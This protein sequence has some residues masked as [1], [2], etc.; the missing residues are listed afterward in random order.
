MAGTIDPNQVK[1]LVDSLNSLTK[2]LG[3]S[4]A[5]SGYSS[6]KTGYDNFK[7]GESGLNTDALRNAIKNNGDAAQQLGNMFKKISLATKGLDKVFDALEKNTRKLNDQQRQATLSIVDMMKAGDDFVKTLDDLDKRATKAAQSIEK[8]KDAVDTLKSATSKLSDLELKR[9]AIEKNLIKARNSKK[10]TS[11]LQKTLNEFDKSI[12]EQKTSIEGL[13]KEFNEIT[14]SFIELNKATGALNEAD[15]EYL[16]NINDINTSNEDYLK[17]INKITGGVEHLKQ[18]NDS[19]AEILVD[20]AKTN[21]EHLTKGVVALKNGLI[22][23]GKLLFTEAIPMAFNDYMARMKNNIPES[24]YG[25]SLLMGVSESQRSDLIGSNRQALRGLGGGNEYSG[26]D[27]QLASL[28]KTAYQFGVYGKDALETALAYQK[29]SQGVGVNAGDVQGQ[30][31]QM[32]LMHQFSEQIGVTDGAL[33]D[34]YDSLGDMGELSV[35]NQ[36]YADKSDSE[37]SKAINKEIYERTKLNVALGISLDM[38]KQMQQEA[39]NKRYAGLENLIKT[40]IGSAMQVQQY[41]QANPNSK[42]ND[43]DDKFFQSVS[44]A[45]GVSTLTD[46][47]DINRYSSIAKS[48]AASDQGRLIKAQQSA[49][50]GNTS[51][52]YNEA[53]NTQ[54]QGI[55]VNRQQFDTEWGKI[56]QQGKTQGNVTGTKTFDDSLSKAVDGLTGPSGFSQAIIEATQAVKGFTQ[57]PIGSAVNAVVQTAGG[58]ILGELIK[59]AGGRVLG[60]MGSAAAGTA[61][62][63]GVSVAA[64]GIAAGA[65]GSAL[66]ATGWV[67]AAGAVGWGI[68]TVINKTLLEGTK[69]GDFIGEN[70]AKMAAFFGSDSAQDAL[71]SNK[72]YD[73]SQ[74][75]TNSRMNDLNAVTA[76]QKLAV[77][78]KGTSGQGMAVSKAEELRSNYKDKYGV[79][80]AGGSVGY[81]SIAPTNDASPSVAAA[82]SSSP[83]NL[84]SQQLQNQ[85]LADAQAGRSDKVEDLLLEIAK[86]N[87]EMN[88]RDGKSETNLDQAKLAQNGSIYKS[89]ADH[90]DFSQRSAKSSV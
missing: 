75:A 43:K 89:Y 45:G 56:N 2:S 14:E 77:T 31:V 78:V 53:I 42:I 20:N 61:V 10:K 32:G 27:T 80:L 68:G 63:E 3:G 47:A 66:A 41:N 6:Q 69:A 88:E 51:S 33:K 76:A 37:R 22:K 82:A 23:A 11:D 67:A 64:G 54:L 50:K 30:K 25:S 13:S 39:V 73:A 84:I 28:Q 4:A 29:T 62:G 9:A 34:F 79:D 81:N 55:G 8:H 26:F 60:S 70:L 72:K 44:S 1:Q 7:N 35:L 18:T 24:G 85:L 17:V 5:S 57:N 58:F 21:G 87:K 83:S 15:V 59:K 65:G 49:A 38:Q 52:M 48:I 12:E 19:I 74:T 36:K 16:K 46:P 71:N 40:Q 86:S 90:L